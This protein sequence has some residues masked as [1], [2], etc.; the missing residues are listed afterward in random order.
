[1]EGLTV[2]TRVRL[3]VAFLV[4]AAAFGASIVLT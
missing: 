1:M 2:G 4:I 3:F